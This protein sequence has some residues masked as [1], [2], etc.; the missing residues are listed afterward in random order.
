M[1]EYHG[2][3]TIQGSAGDE[4]SAASEAT[5]RAV[6]VELAELRVLPG[7][8]DVRT[9]NGSAQLHLAG[10][11]NHRGGQ[12]ELVLQTFRR[13][14]EVAPGSYGLLFVRD[15]EDA[16]GRDN[17]FQV[18]AMRR[19]SVTETRDQHLSPCIPVIEDEE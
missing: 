16:V 5:V 6:E 13:I 10:L 1:F 12:G 11:S 9:V 7:L 18:L 2:W 14:S 17:E 3:I 19:G 15:D 8:V 4:S